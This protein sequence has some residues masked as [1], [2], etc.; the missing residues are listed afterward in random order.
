L[1]ITTVAQSAVIRKRIL[2]IVESLAQIHTFAVI[3]SGVA[4]WHL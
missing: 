4:S 3:S 1:G 2:D